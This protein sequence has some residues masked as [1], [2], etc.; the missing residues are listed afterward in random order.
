MHKCPVCF[1]FS[2]EPAECEICRNDNRD[3]S[4]ICVVESAKDVMVMEK[5][6]GYRGVYHVLGGVIS[7]MDGVNPEDINLNN[8]I[9]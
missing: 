7:P 3:H 2:S 1:G 6:R 4:L 8:L 9:M 5:V